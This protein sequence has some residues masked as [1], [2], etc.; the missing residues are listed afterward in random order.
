MWDKVKETTAI[1]SMKHMIAKDIRTIMA[2]TPSATSHPASTF[3]NHSRP[4]TSF[5]H[6]F[7]VT[8]FNPHLGR[9]LPHRIEFDLQSAEAT[10]T[11]LMS[12]FYFG[13]NAAKDHE[14]R[15]HDLGPPERGKPATERLLDA[16][17][18][19]NA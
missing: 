16:C 1:R 9:W 8:L 13:A 14:V 18:S 2:A 17:R 11:Y 3:Q 4:M 5:P 6:V 10:K 19:D 12:S 15:I 7:G